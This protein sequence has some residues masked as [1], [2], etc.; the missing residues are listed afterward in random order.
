M[1]PEVSRLVSLFEITFYIAVVHFLLPITIKTTKAGT[2]SL[3]LAH[4]AHR[5]SAKRGVAI[6]RCP[7]VRPSVTLVICGHTG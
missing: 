3:F 6:V 4:D 7:S 2:A 1:L 5:P